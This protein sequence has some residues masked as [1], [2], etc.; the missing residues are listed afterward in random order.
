MYNRV[1][2]DD[3]TI[4]DVHPT[5]GACDEIRPDP[6]GTDQLVGVGWESGS[7]TWVAAGTLFT[8][9]EGGDC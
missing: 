7:F 1:R 6:D 9:R 8:V 2:A 3:L 4:G 5:Y